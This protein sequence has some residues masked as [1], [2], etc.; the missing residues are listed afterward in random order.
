MQKS[1]IFDKKLEISSHDL[2]SLFAGF[3]HLYLSQIQAEKVVFECYKLFWQLSGEI[4][5]PKKS[6]V[7]EKYLPFLEVDFVFFAR[8]IKNV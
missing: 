1:W 3:W 4:Q 5:V 7:S 2:M 8:T 6:N